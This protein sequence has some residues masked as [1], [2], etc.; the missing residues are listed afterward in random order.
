M[1][2]IPSGRALLDPEPLLRRAGLALDM[3]Y[4]DLGAGMLGHFVLPASQ[5]VGPAGMVYAVDI[6]K[7]ALASIESRTQLESITNVKTVWADLERPGG[8]KIPAGTL[9]I[10]SFVN[11]AHLLVGGSI[12]I[13]EAM[14]LLRSHGRVLVVD[15][16]PSAGSLLVSSAHRV[17]SDEV[18][19]KF[20]QQGLQLLDEFSAG[21]QHWGLLFRRP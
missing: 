7:S 18:K 14:R 20:L 19:A 16:D 5:I 17:A 10:V 9:D 3:R 6:L 1:P 2:V 4:A 21:P 11:V 8:V 12:P 15:W 13:Q